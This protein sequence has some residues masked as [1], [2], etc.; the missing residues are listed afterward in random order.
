[1]KDLI[2]NARHAIAAA[3]QSQRIQAWA[4]VCLCCEILGCYPYQ[5][6]GPRRDPAITDCRHIVAENLIRMGYTYEQAGNILGGRHHTTIL[7]GRRRY[8]DL[9]DT[10]PVFRAK[11]EATAAAVTA[12]FHPEAESIAI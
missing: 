8:S 7:S 10:D 9:H 1:M 6:F 5:V 12:I 4:V 2:K 3:E 11:A